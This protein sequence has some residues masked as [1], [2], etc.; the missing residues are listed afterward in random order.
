MDPCP[1]LIGREEEM[2]Q[3][4]ALLDAGGG[5]AIVSG[6]AGIG[7][8]RLVR[9][10]AAEA[11]E[12]GRVVL[13]GR[14]EEVA[15]PGPF[16]L[17]VDLLESIA[18][19][20]SPELKRDALILGHEL[21]RPGA[22]KEE[23]LSPTPRTVAAEIRGLA[24]RLRLPPVIILEDLHWAD[25][26]SHSVVLHLLRAALDDQHVIVASVRSEGIERSVSLTRLVDSIARDRS[27]KLVSLGPLSD[28][29]VGSM[30]EA[31]SP[32]GFDDVQR[33]RIIRLGEGVPFF[34]EELADA[35]SARG[36]P[37]S[38]ELVVN[39]RLKGL[40]DEA[41]EVVRVCSLMVGAIDS[42]V[43]AQ[44][45][46]I[47]TES[48]TKCLVDGVM[49]GLLEDRE[50]K[51]V[52][53]HSLVRD[54]VTRGIVSVQLTELH[55]RIA[56]AFEKLYAGELELHCSALARHYEEAGEPEAAARFLI[57]AGDRALGFAAT[58]DARA[59][60]SRA[61]SLSTNFAAQAK[62]GLGEV[63]F[64]EGNVREAVTLFDSVASDLVS[65]DDSSGAA[66]ALGRLAW[67]LR[68]MAE[69]DEVITTLDKGLSLVAGNDDARENVELLVQKGQM[70][71]FLFERF[72]EAK[73]ILQQAIR[74]A[75]AQQDD[76]L[77]AQASDGLAQVADWEGDVESALR[78]GLEAVSRALKSN[79]AEVIGRTHNNHA[80][81]LASYGR[82]EEGRLILAEGRAHL[83]RAHGAAGVSALD[84]SQAW[85]AW[86]MGLPNEVASLTALGQAAW[87]RWRGYRRILEVW[88]A[89]EQGQQQLAESRLSAAWN[90]LGSGARTRYLA[91]AELADYETRQVLYAEGVLRLHWGSP[92]EAVQVAGAV[93]AIDSQSGGE[94]FD[95][96]QGL[97]LLT[98]AFVGVN[99]ATQAAQI[100][101]ETE[102]LLS[103][104][105]RYTYLKS[106]LDELK[107]L[108]LFL[109]KDFLAARELFVSAAKSFE[110]CRNESDRARCYRRAA[111]A[112][113][114]SGVETG[115]DQ[116]VGLLRDAL[117]ISDRSGAI[118]EKNRIESMLRELGV[119]SRAGRPRRSDQRL[120]SPREAEVAVLVAA[121]ETNSDIARDLFLSERTVQDHISNALKKLNLHGRAG[122]AAWA[123]RQGLV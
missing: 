3:L 66:R 13:W 31:I 47:P 26:A 38:L 62:R 117:S 19:R 102:A 67:A 18:E 48:V 77:A 35:A 43:V 16:A 32:D 49:L 108:V 123:A 72:S 20:G 53:R 122:L 87:Q 82:P 39:S 22:D 36:L 78:Y 104:V 46:E 52:F 86:L 98:H 28:D 2:A 40:G 73:P 4:R 96:A 107:G 37:K 112:A 90:D 34:I 114:A 120:L 116:A 80:V 81:K 110:E 7:K 105:D 5:V 84:V 8:S 61:W 97:I 60:F 44:V 92:E 91:Q 115:R 29:E 103:P 21:M 119:R 74:L 23:R 88:A 79:S 58:E 76:S 41:L 27:P 99:A 24:G 54:A 1:I 45:L 17:I 9:E 106:H 101:A 15:Q 63:A 93:V 25:E 109:G 118:A 55:Q 57:M 56:N 12:R 10:F 50:D 95:R 113:I 85:I 51:L 70:L 42:H 94:L 69:S 83:L 121:G 100:V 30:I 33:G 71:S 64:R 11:S 14:P 68:S 75:I 65:A 6:E 111:E 59:N 89:V